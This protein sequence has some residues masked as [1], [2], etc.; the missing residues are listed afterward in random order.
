MEY[1]FKHG[2]PT[3]SLC[4]IVKNEAR[5]LE[6]CLKSVADLVDEI[7]VVD[8]GS[9]DATLDIARR[10]KARIYHYPWTQDFAAARNESLKHATSDWIL[11]L[12]ADERLEARSKR[13]LLGL[14]RNKSILC[15]NVLIDSPLRDSRKGHIS[16]SH[17]LFRNL[18]GIR[19]S[20]RVHEQIS[21][22]IA[23][24]KGKECFS[25]IRLKHLGYAK[26]A[27]EMSKKSRRNYELLQLQIRDEPVNAYWHFS[28][29]QNQILSQ[30]YREARESLGIALRIGGL[31]EDILCSIYNN[32]SEVHL[33]LAKLDEAISYA[34]RA[35]SITPNQCTA[36]LL[37]FQIYQTQGNKKKQLESLEAAVGVVEE[38]KTGQQKVSVEAYVDR[39]ALYVSLAGLYLQENRV[40]EARGYFQR[41]LRID[42]DNVSALNGLADCLL[43]ERRFIEASKILE[44]LDLVSP[45]DL[46][47]KEKLAW[48][49][50][51]LGNYPRAIEIYKHLLEIEPHNVV[52]NRQMAALCHKIGLTAQ[53]R[54]YLAKAKRHS[55]SSV[56]SETTAQV[57]P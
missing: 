27:P 29:A 51:K 39:A 56:A 21:P 54:R 40:A 26:D 38:Q 48:L 46:A 24:L 34:E 50:I 35:L 15:V 1:G 23:G 36:H 25:T 18:P 44:H 49:A 20:G 33:K 6:A 8:T 11:Y 52:L 47:R 53:A 14:L 13:E 32:L 31:P 55:H 5:Y 37:L 16:R 57:L 41:A 19:F 17:R 7:I 2:K 10:F 45:E 3:L 22:S 28:L 4:M 42:P 9:T 30:K 12:D 43:E